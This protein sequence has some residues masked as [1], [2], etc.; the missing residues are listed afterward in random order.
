MLMKYLRLGMLKP[1]EKCGLGQCPLIFAV[2]CGMSL[3]VC[4]K[5][6]QEFG[7]DPNS[8]DESGDTLLH[9]ALNLEN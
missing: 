1:K 3:S 6:V 9:Y 4:K 2:D 5:L 8:F 7:C